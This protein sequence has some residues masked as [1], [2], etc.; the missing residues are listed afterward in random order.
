MTV[1]QKDLPNPKAQ[2]SMRKR[3]LVWPHMKVSIFVKGDPSSFWVLFLIIPLNHITLVELPAA[4]SL[5]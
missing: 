3:N 2:K 5:A 4:L 1:L